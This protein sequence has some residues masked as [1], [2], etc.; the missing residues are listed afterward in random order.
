MRYRIEPHSLPARIRGK[1]LF[2]LAW[3]TLLVAM[4]RT[5]PTELWIGDSHAMSFNRKITNSMFMRA[6]GRVLILRAGARLMYSVSRTG[7]PPEVL[8]VARLVNRFG[9]PGSL[10]PVFSAGEI[11]VRVHLASRADQPFDFVAGYVQE[12]IKVAA[13]L[14]ATT[15]AF[16]VPPPPVDIPEEHVWFPIN[17]TVDERIGVHTK[18]RNTLAEAIAAVPDAVLLDFTDVLAGPSG[19]MPLE[20]TSDGAH[21]NLVA[22]GRIRTRIAEGHLLD[23]AGRGVQAD[24]RQ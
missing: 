8:R 9:R 18:L 23:P 7:L 21:T 3:P 2:L 24:F 19:A 4:R 22:V 14:K 13:L 11:D 6:P 1:L 20:L 12:C 15:I 10:L 16:V 17:G 5:R